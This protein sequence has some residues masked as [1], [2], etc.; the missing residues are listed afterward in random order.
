MN[1]KPIKTEQD[2]Q[3]ALARLEV[4]F[5]ADINTPAG[6]ELE[7]LGIMIERYEDEHHPLDLD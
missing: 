7:L 1:I 5:D 2:Y 3:E 6:D 4:I